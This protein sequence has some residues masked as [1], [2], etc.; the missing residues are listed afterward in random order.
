MKKCPPG[1]VCFESMTLVCL[2]GL[3]V[4]LLVFLPPMLRS[5][6]TGGGAAANTH[7]T[8]S[9]HHHHRRDSPPPEFI[10]LGGGGYGG[11]GQ[12][13]VFP[14]FGAPR[15][16]SVPTNVNFVNADY[17]QVGILTPTH[18]DNKNKILPLFGRPLYSSR[19]KWQY[20]SMSNQNHVVKL[21]IRV[22]GKSG[23]TDYGVD[24]LF[25]GDHVFVEGYN[26]GFKVT[27]YENDTI[28]YL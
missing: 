22:K 8:P 13:P 26:D 20:Y 21:P 6:S 15:L 9:H 4:V 17:R 2:L 12:P 18:G 10:A 1:V 3:A 25:S 27:M 28:R 16:V 11:A 5:W 7:Y 19:S 23:T 24:E 14:S